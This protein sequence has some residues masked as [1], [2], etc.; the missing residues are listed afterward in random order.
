[1]SL[2]QYKKKRS[3]KDTPEPTAGKSKGK[4]LTFVIQQ[5]DASHMHY[6]FRLEMEGVLKSWAIPKGPSMD[7]SVKRLAMMVEDHPYAYKDFEGIIPQGNYGAGTVIVWDEGTYTP[8]DDTDTKKAQEQSLLK[9]LKAGSLKFSLHGHKVKGEF[10]LVR[11]KGMGD[12]AWLLIKHN[13]RFATQ[14][15]VTRRSKSVKSGK[16]IAALTKAAAGSEDGAVKQGKKA[17]AGKK[18][19]GK[20]APVG[21]KVGKKRTKESSTKEASAESGG[22]QPSAEELLHKAPRAAFPRDLSPML[23][24]LVDKPFDDEDWSF[25]IKWDGYRALAF[26]HKKTAT[27]QS[28]N[29]KSFDDRFYPVLDALKQWDTDAVLDGEIVVVDDKGISHF[30]ALQNWRSE[31]DGHLQYYVFDILWYQGHILTGLQLGERMGIL[32]AMIDGADGDVIRSGMSVVGRGVQFFEAARKLGL[33]GIMAKRLDSPY[34]PGE[35]SKSWLKIK[36]Q[37]R[38]EVVIIG[39]TKNES[40]PRP[41]SSLLLA[42]YSQQ[43]LRYVGKVGTGFNEAM[44]KSMLKKFKPLVTRQSPLTAE[45][46]YNKPSRFRPSPPR[47]TATWLKPELVCEIAFTE[48]TE[49][50]MF[51]HP[52]FKGLREDKDARKVVMEKEIDTEEAVAEAEEG[53]KKAPSGKKKGNSRKSSQKASGVNLVK[54]PTRTGRRTLLNPTDKSQV[55]KVKGQELKFTHL[56]KIFWPEEKITKRDLINYYYQVAP[57]ILPYLRDRPQSLNRFPDGYKGKH[58]YQKDVS[59]KIPGWLKTMPYKSQDDDRQKQ[60][61]VITDEASLLYLANYGCIEMN[62]WSSTVDDPDYPDW[63]IL[64][65]DPGQKTGF[66]Q[67]IE[68]ARIIHE[69]LEGAGIPSYCKTSGSTGMHIYLPLGRQ[70]TYEEAKEFARVI[71]TMVHHQAPAI[72]SIERQVSRRKGKMYLDF[73]QNRPQATLAAPYAVRPKPGATVSM[74]LYWEE[75]KKGLTMQSFTLKNVPAMLA[76]RGDIFKGV[77]GKGLDMIRALKALQ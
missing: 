48:V 6:D 17:G 37:Q 23:A 42:V 43:E 32:S 27:L 16:R 63:C 70:Y 50:G 55:R 68:A 53:G 73:L 34:E 67:V 69:L 62:P 76:E 54:P 21:K 4:E 24:T 26:R 56:D 66:D 36:V 8:I 22:K 33:E 30:H 47:A 61:L 74:P 57:Y 45:P 49:D 31:A 2:A 19:A 9:Q 11:T 39:Y 12:N 77:M 10:A 7:P 51:R 38:Q 25:E 59:G 65:L 72:T 28:R 71:V 41:F 20:K 3:F 5:H 14:T 40:T 18:A 29:Q 58:F 15:D 13:D 44:Q 46:D 1:M 75:V 52:V 60:F 64:D 35:R